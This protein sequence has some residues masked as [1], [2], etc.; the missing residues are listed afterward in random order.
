[1]CSGVLCSPLAPG[2]PAVWHTH[3][4]QLSPSALQ[5]SLALG[6]EQCSHVLVFPGKMA[7]PCVVGCSHSWKWFMSQKQQK[8]VLILG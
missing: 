1:M 5:S 2:S 7:L 3:S 4:L 6:A 8:S